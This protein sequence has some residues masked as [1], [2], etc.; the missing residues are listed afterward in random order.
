[1]G[2]MKEIFMEIQQDLEREYLIDDMLAQGQS[3]E[4]YL[5]LQK[6]PEINILNTKIEVG[7]GKSTIEVGTKE[8]EPYRQT[9]VVGLGF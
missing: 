4:D 6:E 3:Y 7:N 2:K 9:E 8:Q 1:M 5:K